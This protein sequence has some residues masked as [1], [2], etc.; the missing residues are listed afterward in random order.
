MGEEGVLAL[1]AGGGTAGQAVTVIAS[2]AVISSFAGSASNTAVVAFVNV[3]PEFVVAFR[4]GSSWSAGLAVSSNTGVAG[5]TS[6]ASG[7]FGTASFA[8]TSV[9]VP[10]GVAGGAGFKVDS[11]DFAVGVSACRTLT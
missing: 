6:R 11:A 3:P 2:I 4:A 9:S 7:A 5:G 1:G 8:G 10:L